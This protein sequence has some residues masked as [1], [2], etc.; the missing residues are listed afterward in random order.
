MRYAAYPGDRVS[1]LD[2]PR[3]R[4]LTGRRGHGGLEFEPDQPYESGSGA[5]AVLGPRDPGNDGDHQLL[6]GGPSA[7]VERVLVQLAEE[8][9][10]GHIVTGSRKPGHR[11]GHLAATQCVHQLSWPE[12]SWIGTPHSLL[13]G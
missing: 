11:S 6:S 13:S 3:L 12:L 4:G 8:A 9:R 1:P 7:M 2:G 10:C 5:G